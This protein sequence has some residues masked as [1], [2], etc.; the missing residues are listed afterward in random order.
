MMKIQQKI[1]NTPQKELMAVLGLSRPL[2]SDIQN[3]RR[4]L[5]PEQE[6]KLTDYFTFVIDESSIRVNI[7]QKNSQKFKQVFLYILHQVGAKPNVGQTVLYKLL[8]FIDFDYYELYEAQLMGLT[9]IKNNYGPT[10]REFKTIIDEMVKQ[11][12]IDIVQ[13]KH[14]SHTQTKYLP[15]IKPDLSLLSAQE[16]TVIDHV[17]ARLSDYS[18]TQLSNLSHTDTPWC[19][20]KEKGNLEYEH[21]FYRNDQLSVRD[22]ETL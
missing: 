22:Y 7:P 6:E 10:P 19:L 12:S 5:T 20:A 11:E 4:E 8:Y 21:V 18:A 3:G 16:L 9:Y 14:F 17:L 1:Q 15:V 13:T 2:I